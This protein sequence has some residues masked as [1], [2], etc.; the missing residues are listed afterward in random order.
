MSEMVIVSSGNVFTDLGTE[1]G[2]AAILQMR[3]KLTNDLRERITASTMTQT[4][5]AQRLGVGQSRVSD[6]MRGK[7]EKFSLEML[8][9]LEARMGRQV[10]LEFA[11]A[12]VQGRTLRQQ[13]KPVQVITPP[14]HLPAR[15]RRADVDMH[16]GLEAAGDAAVVE[17]KSRACFDMLDRMS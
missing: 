17:Y 5:A 16:R 6:L 9:T 13:S 4:E 15:I 14:P 7:W 2:E 8:I 12:A 10:I 11:G 1:P 3:A